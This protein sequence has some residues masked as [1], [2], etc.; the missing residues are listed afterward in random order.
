MARDPLHLIL[1][2]D[3]RAGTGKSHVI[4]LLSDYLQQAVQDQ[5]LLSP[6]LR[7]APTGVA[8]HSNSGCTLHTLF[9]LPVSASTFAPLTIKSWRRAGQLP[10]LS[11]PDYGRK[12]NDW[13]T[14]AGAN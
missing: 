8:V 9:Q 12:I 1:Q 5:G 6:V 7:T 13:L 4:L 2:V 11:I 10:R 3:A 14:T